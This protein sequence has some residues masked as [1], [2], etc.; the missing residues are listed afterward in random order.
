MKERAAAEISR[1]EGDVAGVVL[2]WR[3]STGRRAESRHGIGLQVGCIGKEMAGEEMAVRR[4][5]QRREPPL[6]ARASGRLWRRRHS[7]DPLRWFPFH[8]RVAHGAGYQLCSTTTTYTPSWPRHRVV[9]DLQSL[10]SLRIEDCASLT[11]PPTRKGS[12]KA[13][14]PLLGACVAGPSSNQP[15][16]ITA[17]VLTLV[18]RAQRQGKVGSSSRVVLCCTYVQ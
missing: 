17:Y 9:V 13:Y 10:R 15:Y 7:A 6:F 18:A 12:A 8:W 4:S 2:R 16:R 11:L 3:W 5:D 1:G 14:A